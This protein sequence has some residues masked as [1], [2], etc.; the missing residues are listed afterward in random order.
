[1]LYSGLYFKFSFANKSIVAI[2]K[3]QIPKIFL[4]KFLSGGKKLM[5]EFIHTSRHSVLD[6]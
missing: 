4:V 5:R 6:V 1:M 2:T 3:A